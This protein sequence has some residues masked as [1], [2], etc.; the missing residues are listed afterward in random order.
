[1]ENINSNITDNSPIPTGDTQMIDGLLNEAINKPNKNK[2]EFI[3]AAIDSNYIRTN[4]QS[5]RSIADIDFSNQPYLK[6]AEILTSAERS[7]YN[8]LTNTLNTKLS[9]IN[10]HILIFPK[11]RLADIFDVNMT[12]NHITKDDRWFYLSQITSKHLDYLICDSDIMNI[13]CGV[14]LDDFYHNKFDRLARDEFVDNLFKNCNIR[15]FRIKE[16]INSLNEYHIDNL[17]D[18]VLDYYNPICPNCGCRMELKR[19]QKG[20]NRDHRFYGCLNWTA[21]RKGCNYSLDIE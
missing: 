6:R 8:L 9:C 10:K 17:I 15:L 12:Y 16:H 13:I 21:D 1:M 18:F 4:K 3:R 20:S 11:I 14:E 5:R 19:A 7:L 2:N